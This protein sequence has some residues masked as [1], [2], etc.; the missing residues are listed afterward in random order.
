MKN[1][2]KHQI[3]NPFLCLSICLMLT[4]QVVI[5]TVM[6]QAGSPKRM[7]ENNIPAHIPIKVQVRNLHHEH[8]ARDLE[9]EI[10]NT[11]DK[12]IY[13]LK[14]LLV[15]PEVK[16]NDESVAFVLRYGRPELLRFSE[17]PTPD[18]IPLSPGA[19]CVLKVP[20]SSSKGWELAK[21]HRGK[22]DPQRISLVFQLLNFGDGTGFGR[23]DGVPI[24]FKKSSKNYMREERKLSL[25]ETDNFRLRSVVSPGTLLQ[26]TSHLSHANFL[27]ASLLTTRDVNSN[28]LASK[29]DICCPG[30][31][32]VYL[33]NETGG[34]N[35]LCG[36]ADWV[37]TASCD[38]PSAMCGTSVTYYEY[39][40]DDYGN[41][42]TCPFFSIIPCREY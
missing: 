26:H 36:P 37:H 8:W 7:L 4:C 39:C 1:S 42:Y 33:V 12:P 5:V 3:L 23:T 24:P 34:Y 13:Y 16:E 17:H 41:E 9:V 11:G 40:S 14:L 18:D 30:S 22:T 28:G 19:S 27:K 35:C 15:M 21:A 2:L 29:P 20:E 31:S 32:C 38:D 6:A 10:K 25:T